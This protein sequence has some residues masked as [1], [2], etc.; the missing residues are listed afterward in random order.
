M[1][2]Y[3]KRMKTS[4]KEYCNSFKGVPIL[5]D[6]FQ[7][8][9]IWEASVQHF[10]F[11]V[12]DILVGIAEHP[13]EIIKAAD[14][15]VVCWVL[16]VRMLYMPCLL[17]LHMSTEEQMCMLRKHLEEILEWLEYGSMIF[18]C[19]C[20]HN[21]FF[22]EDVFGDPPDPSSYSSMLLGQWC[23][24]AQALVPSQKDRSMSLQSWTR[25]SWEMLIFR[26]IHYLA[27]EPKEYTEYLLYKLILCLSF[28]HHGLLYWNFA[29]HCHSVQ[30]K[31]FL[32]HFLIQ[33]I[34][35]NRWM[36]L[37]HKRCRI[38][39]RWWVKRME[40]QKRTLSHV[41]FRFITLYFLAFPWPIKE[42]RLWKLRRRFGAKY[43]KGCEGSTLPS[44]GVLIVGRS[45]F[46]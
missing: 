16:T 36:R 29:V 25:K 26:Q 38:L 27:W 11:F 10:P 18:A 39:C 6:C 2:L 30:G 35:W 33:W 7:W 13:A 9:R 19:V 46:G 15:G 1:I 40:N 4:N 34:P 22:W 20:W 5:I 14:H 44:V 8:M 37:W 24:S 17:F 12:V 43:V 31:W 32:W 41:C 21:M 28:E 3:M 45:I 42:R 23:F